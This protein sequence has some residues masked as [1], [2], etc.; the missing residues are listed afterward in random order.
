[1]P[2]IVYAV[3]TDEFQP[4]STKRLGVF[5]KYKRVSDDFYTFFELCEVAY[6]L[7]EAPEHMTCKILEW[8]E[9]EYDYGTYHTIE[10]LIDAMAGV[11]KFSRLKPK[12][13]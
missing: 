5:Q 1:V 7:P 6:P 11:D 3:N 8:I 4:T 13:A 10:Q 12:G 9:I 2:T